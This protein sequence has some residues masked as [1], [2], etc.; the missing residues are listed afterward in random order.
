MRDERFTKVNLEHLKQEKREWE[1]SGPVVI[2]SDFGSLVGH[3]IQEIEM[4]RK[5]QKNYQDYV[6][7]V[8]GGG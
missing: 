8:V 2:S 7:F 6:K 3:A 1:T 5:F 4:H